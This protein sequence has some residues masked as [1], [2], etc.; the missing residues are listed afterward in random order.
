M[1]LGPAGALPPD[2]WAI[3]AFV[4]VP[5]GMRCV[6]LPVAMRPDCYMAISPSWQGVRQRDDARLDLTSGPLDF[7]TR[8]LLELVAPGIPQ[9]LVAPSWHV[10]YSS[11]TAT[12]WGLGAFADGTL[13]SFGPR[14]T[15][16]GCPHFQMDNEPDPRRALAAALHV[17]RQERTP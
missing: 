15:G 1:I 9:P 11:R 8:A 4:C 17:A 2:E 5:P 12:V 10:S 16:I 6:L 3:G 14:R 13:W 7:G